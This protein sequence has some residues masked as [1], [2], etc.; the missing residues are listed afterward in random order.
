[1]WDALTTPSEEA[2]LKG[3]EAMATAPLVGEELTGPKSPPK[4]V[5][6]LA[7]R[8]HSIA[9]GLRQERDIAKWVTGYGEFLSTCN[10]CHQALKPA[11]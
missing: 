11:K 10:A 8:A 5:D 2:W 4:E 1:M 6:A 7:K 3:S 9:E